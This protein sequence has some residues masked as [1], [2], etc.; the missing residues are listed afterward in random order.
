MKWIAIISHF[1]RASKYLLGVQS[2]TFLSVLTPN[3]ICVCRFSN[4]HAASFISTI[5]PFYV[6]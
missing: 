1:I 2:R 5:K 3:F 4:D 6:D